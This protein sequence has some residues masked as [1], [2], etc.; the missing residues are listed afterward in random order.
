MWRWM[1]RWMWKMEHGVM[2]WE[3]RADEKV[4]KNEREMEHD[5]VG[6]DA[7]VV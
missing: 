6:M 2:V 1:W 7:A 3:E 4:R 5:V